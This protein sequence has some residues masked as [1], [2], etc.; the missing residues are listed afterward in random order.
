MLE[1]ANGSRHRQVRILPS[2]GKA[3][4]EIEPASQ[5]EDTNRSA[6]PTAPLETIYQT[7]LEVGNRAVAAMS[8]FD[9]SEVNPV[10]SDRCF[11]DSTP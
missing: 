5:K 6:Y 1:T 11:V 3:H 8:L 9:Y 7:V 10:G 4:I 2:D